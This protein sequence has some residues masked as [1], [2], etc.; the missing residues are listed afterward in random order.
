MMTHSDFVHLHIHTQYSLLDGACRI[1]QLLKLAKEY[2]MPALAITDHGN[3]FGAVEFYKKAT[4]AGIKPII[5][6][7]VYVAPQSRLKKD[8][9]N[10]TKDTSYHLVLLVKN[11]IGYRNLVKLVSSAYTE[12]FYYKPRIDKELLAKH[13]EGLI[14]LSACLKGEIPVLLNA[15]LEEKAIQVAQEYKGIMEEGCFYL[16][17]QKNGIKEQDRANE[18]L[19]KIGKELSLPLVATNDC[20]YLAKE[21]AK[22]HDI[23]LCIQTSKTIEDT[24]RLSF[25]TDEF[26]F[27]SPEVMKGLFADIPEVIE[28]TVSIAQRCNFEFEFGKLHLPHYTVPDNFNLDTYLDHLAKEGLKER[29]PE[30]DSNNEEPITKNQERITR[31]ETEL[32]IIHKMGYS[33][34]FLIVWDFINYAK[35]HDIPVGPGRGSAAGSL[36]A[37]ALGITDIDPLRYKLLFERFLNPERVSMPDIDVDFCMEKREDVI[38]YVT[39]KYG[40]ENV[41]QII[42]F[43]TMAA[44]GVI[45]DVGRTLNMPYSEVD[46]I[47]KLVPNILNI[48]LQEAIKQEPKLQELRDKDSRVQELLKIALTLEGLPR[49]ASIHAAGIVI[50]PRP[51]TEY[52]PLYKG[53]K[54]EVVTQFP[55]NILESIGLLKMDFLGLKTLTVIHNAINLIEKSKGLRLDISTIPIDDKVTFELLSKAQTIGIFQLESSG[56]RDLLRKLKPEYF[57]ELIAAVALYRPG[58]LGSGM[59][60]DFIK[61]KH[62]KVPIEYDLP[63]LEPVLRDTYGIIVYQEQVMQIASAVAGFTMGQADLLRRAMGKKK[64]EVMEKQSQVFIAG[65]KERGKDPEIAKKIF[66]LMAYFAGYGF[67]KSHSAAYAQITYQTAYLKAHYPVEFMAALLTSEIDNTDKIVRYI[68]ECKEMGIEVLPPDVNI[69]ISDFYVKD[70]KIRF[71]LAA[72]KN[73]G[74]AA[75]SAII[76]TR[77]EHGDFNSIYDFCEY[78]DLRV[79]NKRVMESLIKCG[80]FDSTGWKRAQIMSVVDKATEFAHFKQKERSDGQINLFDLFEESEPKAKNSYEQKPEIEEWGKSELLAFEKEV[81]GFYITGHPLSAYEKEVKRFASANTSNLNKL[82]DGQNL[83]IGGII[84]SLKTITTKKNERMAFATIEDLY[85]LVELIIFP[86]LYKKHAEILAADKPIYIKGI[87]DA[88]EDVNKIVANEIMLLSD[89]RS[90]MTKNVHIRLSTLGLAE[91]HLLSLEKILNSYDGAGRCNVLLH[92]LLGNQDSEVVIAVDE[93]IKVLPDERLVTDIEKVFGGDVVYFE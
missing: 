1:D 15:G 78:V 73:V 61:R 37:Y 89:V 67:N 47:A 80:A 4:A 65:A 81:T 14:A 28:N 23:L 42:T 77:E 13:A 51:L 66:D 12:G 44:K 70:N 93:K 24:K 83:T 88:K 87:L 79:V 53:Q 3:M 38:K 41:A 86:E 71:G 17:V 39:N 31:F 76:R 8:S 52:V 50:T 60:D 36:V 54:G 27:K 10:N 48:T 64:H 68:S 22:A 35:T 45:R 5:G 84:A 57:E 91:E 62:G 40:K 32:E 25:S 59:V 6:C 75:V 74:E 56:M 20:H 90:S 34:Y 69:S 55:M 63:E 33:G 46:K 58:P 11:E 72:V 43:G 49:H 26:Y 7:E 9:S 21:D 16:E 18:G 29:Y 85:G 82:T 92:L 19:I 2:K 30:L